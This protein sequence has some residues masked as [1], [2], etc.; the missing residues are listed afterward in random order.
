M[1]CK[2]C[3]RRLTKEERQDDYSFNNAFCFRCQ[4]LSELGDGNQ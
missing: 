3:D 4:K 2:C 1:R